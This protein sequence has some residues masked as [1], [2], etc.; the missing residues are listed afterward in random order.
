MYNCISISTYSTLIFGLFWVDSGG[1]C[2]VCDR[3]LVWN[4]SSH[5]LHVWTQLPHK[6]R[7]R[8]E[9][10]KLR[11]IFMINTVY[12]EVVVTIICGQNFNWACY[13]PDL[14]E[15]NHTNNVLANLRLL[16][17]NFLKVLIWSVNDRGPK[18]NNPVCSILIMILHPLY[19]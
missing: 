6:R 3:A 19:D 2:A 5:V 12:R 8:T 7:R 16:E 10:G 15:Q 9:I 1:D 11:F 13:F 14:F 18:K 4:R 17:W